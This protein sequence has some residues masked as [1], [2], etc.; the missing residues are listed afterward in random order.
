M[1]LRR[2]TEADLLGDATDL[3]RPRGTQMQSHTKDQLLG[4][5]V[6][7]MMDDETAK[8]EVVFDREK[9][10]SKGNLKGL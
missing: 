8:T 9:E 6:Q 1:L 7:A 5:H 2:R 10:E 4:A 3:R